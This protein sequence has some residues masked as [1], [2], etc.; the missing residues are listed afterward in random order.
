MNI[1]YNKLWKLLIDKHMT[2]TELKLKIG[3]SSTTLA[4]LSKNESVS[5]ESIIKIC[6]ELNCDISDI[7]EIKR[8]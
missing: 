8:S 3:I 7:M 2:K 6:N 1:S 5:M 4:K